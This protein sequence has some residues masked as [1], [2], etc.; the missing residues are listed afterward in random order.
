MTETDPMFNGRPQ[1]RMHSR[2][3]PIALTHAAMPPARLADPVTVIG[4]LLI[5]ILVIGKSGVMA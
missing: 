1:R 5:V 3:R 4:L 2:Q